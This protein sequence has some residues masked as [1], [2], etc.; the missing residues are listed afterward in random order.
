MSERVVTFEQFD[1]SVYMFKGIAYF[2]AS[3]VT[4]ALGYTNGS[5]A[6]KAHV[7]PAHTKTFDVVYMGCG[8][9]SDVLCR[10]ENAGNPS[11]GVLTKTRVVKRACTNSSG[12]VRKKWHFGSVSGLSQK[13]YRKFVKPDASCDMNRSL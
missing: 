3:D 1:V 8:S 10:T 11:T 4:S 6:V 5:Q 2:R 9:V 13:S 12:T 7:N